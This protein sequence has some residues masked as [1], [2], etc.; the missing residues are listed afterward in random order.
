MSCELYN[1]DHDHIADMLHDD[2]TF[3]AFDWA[4]SAFTRTKRMMLG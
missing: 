3:L 2:E 4:S 1:P